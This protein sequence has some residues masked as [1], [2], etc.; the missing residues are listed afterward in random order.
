MCTY[1]TFGTDDY[2]DASC[3]HLA[4]GPDHD[5]TL[6]S[7]SHSGTESSLSHDSVDSDTDYPLSSSQVAFFC[8]TAHAFTSILVTFL[9]LKQAGFAHL[10]NLF[11]CVHDVNPSLI[12]YV[13]KLDCLSL[14]DCIKA[15]VI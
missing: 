7:S 6:V 11:A 13:Q 5:S 8:D 14:Y 9:S 4:N 2:V 10:A 3:L 12:A 15:T 1:R